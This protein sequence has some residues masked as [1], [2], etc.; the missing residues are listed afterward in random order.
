[1]ETEPVQRERIL[2]LIPREWLRKYLDL[3]S[4]QA[5]TELRLLDPR[6]EIV[7]AAPGGASGEEETC[8][9][10][11][12][13]KA[14]EAASEGPG[15]ERRSE[16]HSVPLLYRGERFGSLAACKRGGEGEDAGSGRTRALLALAAAQMEG[17]ACAAYEVESL[18]AEV[19]RVYEELTLIYGLTERLGGTVE[20]EEICRVVA[21]EAEKVLKPSDIVVQLSDEERGALR[22]VFASGAHRSEALGFA[23]GLEE[24]VIGRVLTS[25][26][27]T[28]VSDFLSEPQEKPWP[29]PVQRLLAVPLVAGSKALGVIFAS[30][31]RDGCNF[32]SREE[33]LLSALSS[34]AA[35]AIKNAQ[36]YSDIKNLFEGFI[37]ASVTAVE[38]RDPTTAGHSARVAMMTV[39]LA[40]MVD[41]SDL[42]LFKNVSFTREQLLEMRYAGLLHDFGKIGVREAVL[43]KEAKL[44]R[45]DMERIRERFSY[46][47]E[48]KRRE[49][50]ERKLEILLTG[51]RAAYLKET[52]GIDAE[53]AREVARLEEEL[54]FVEAANDPRVLWS[55]LPELERL[56]ALTERYYTDPGGER[57]PYLTPFEFRNLHVLKGSLNEEERREIES[58][59]THSYNF[60]SRIPWS[61]SFPRIAE[62]V[63][64]HHEKLD[65]SG[66]PRELTAEDIP[67][68]AK[69]MTV[70]DIFDA[71]TAWDRPYK[72]SVSV[73]K[74]L[75]I[76]EMEA[77]EGK[78]EP[79]LVQIFRDA[80]VY[81]AVEGLRPRH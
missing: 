56:S 44:F 68:Q 60:L 65:G 16:L 17:L 21:D 58:H 14:C 6:G 9:E 22:T 23:P 67:L 2:D 31:K 62:M 32:D 5:G 53:L 52:E 51:G 27:P 7:M 48:R 34:V 63:Y 47:G 39:E 66:Y 41:A 57:K 20:I 15:G 81:T 37:D 42:P 76:L 46:I 11:L 64:A 79:H 59:V 43:L 12:W 29:F 55:D 24:G 28:L 8:P 73:E 36:L 35:L 72:K 70:A 61:R 3:A 69:M 1:M 10:W 30:D 54:K 77:R 74:A 40:K 18:S 25:H 49:A 33:K 13:S 19:V 45:G 4:K 50:L 26:R 80:K 75:F 71:L 78:L 38:A